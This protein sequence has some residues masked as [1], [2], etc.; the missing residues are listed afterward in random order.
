M[1]ACREGHEDV[2]QLILENSS[3]NIDLYAKDMIGYDAFTWACWQGQKNIVQLFLDHSDPKI[4]IALM[5][6]HRKGHQEIVQ[7][8]KSRSKNV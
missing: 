2:V 1:E 5:V 6:A 4:N 8:I 3:P 7:L